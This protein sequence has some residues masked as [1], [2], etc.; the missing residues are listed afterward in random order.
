M[1][2]S[3]VQVIGKQ[4][5]TVVIFAILAFLLNPIDFGILGMAMAWIAFI[6]VF[7]E[8][9]FGA[10]LVQRHEINLN[11]FSTIFFINVALG[12]SLTFIGIL[13]SWP[14]A[15][16]FKTQEVQPIMAVLSLG[17]VI[18]SFSLTYIA[19][20]QRELRFRDLAIR[21]ISAS[22]I[23]GI[24]GIIF[25]FLK[26]GVWSLVVQSLINYAVGTILLWNMSKWKPQLKEF[27]FQNVK[28]LWDYSS[29]IFGFQIF[30]YFAQNNDKLI[31]GYLLGPIA[32]GLYTFAYKLTVFPVITIVGS[33]GN[34][35][36]PKFSKIQEDL[37]TIKSSYLFINKVINCIVAPC[38]VII[39]LLSPSLV[40]PIF[41]Q[42][43]VSTIPLIQILA[44]LGI[45]IPWISPAGQVMKAL[46]HPGW[47]LNWSVLI[48][49]LVSLFI[50][51]G[52]TLNVTGAT[53]GLVT[54]HIFALPIIFWM[55]SKLL[56]Y[57]L[58][59][60]LDS[61]APSFL[62]S[63]L[64]ALLLWGILRNGEILGHFKI[65]IGLLFGITF[66]LIIMVFI[67]KPFL[68]VLFRKIMALR[69]I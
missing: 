30:K 2:W 7:S 53:I 66:Y 1:I 15:L 3:I 42:K 44:I 21:D 28:D 13:L 29:K 59:D 61:F 49:I 22:L 31:I 25:A 48:T 55:L 52:S 9:G 56:H 5:L 35:L 12:I 20:A 32:L 51:A 40:P 23:G 33:I 10:A 63:L 27:S 67:D 34:Y 50:W 57:S 8:L 54:A 68:K 36:F 19:I 16:F 46:N 60:I 45:I 6:Q 47:L 26:F 65:Y 17:F 64:M 39:A 11:Y 41:G 43:W 18:N 4:G 69:S 62:S 24:A 38:M 14:C 58:K 37:E